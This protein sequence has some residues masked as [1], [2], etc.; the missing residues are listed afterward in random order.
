M[1]SVF[2]TYF[3]LY[4]SSNYYYYFH[5]NNDGESS[6]CERLNDD[7]ISKCGE[8]YYIQ[9]RFE[10]SADLSELDSLHHAFLSKFVDWLFFI[11]HFISSFISVHSLFVVRQSECHVRVRFRRYQVTCATV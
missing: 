4:G 6:F 3:R 11:F 1:Y 10:A 2:C 7:V 5:D 9:T 8:V